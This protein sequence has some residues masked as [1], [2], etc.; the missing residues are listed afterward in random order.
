MTHDELKEII[1]Q[2][3]YVLPELVCQFC[4]CTRPL[5]Q[6]GVE[7]VA[8]EYRTQEFQADIAALNQEGKLVAVIEVVNTHSPNENVLLAQSELE[9]A[10]YVEMDALDNGF[11]GYCSTFCWTNRKESNV[12]SWKAPSCEI[13]GRYFFS[14]EYQYELF[15]WEGLTGFVGTNCIEC[16]ARHDGGQWLSPGELALGHPEDRIPGPN[17]DV[18]A[19]FLAFEEAN[20]W[21]KVWA[22]RTMKQSEAW[23]AETDTEVRL[24]QVEDAFNREHWNEG[25]MLLQPI[26]A[27]K[28]DSPSGPRLFAWNHENCLR[29]A[30]AWRRLREHRLSC[31]PPMLQTAIG[32]RPPLCDAAI[33]PPT[34]IMTHRGFPDGRFT[35]CGLDRTKSSEPIIA[36]MSDTP[37]C[38]RCRG[39]RYS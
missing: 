32:F 35:D 9:A 22:N 13:C 7:R 33:D 15:D 24:S 6:M 36:S 8:T 27:P 19:L 12:S 5:P 4:K 38:E 26:G 34:P 29:T 30:R 2:A 16:A 21:A 10:F 3:Y 31:L 17:A 37:T 23:S 20:F 18:L 1:A 14:M 28:W 25:Q 39:W 11:T